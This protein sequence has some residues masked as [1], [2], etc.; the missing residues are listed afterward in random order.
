MFSAS[1]L[2]MT[3]M[4]QRSRFFAHCIMRL[5][6]I[7]MPFWAF[8]T[9]AA[10]STAGN[11]PIARPMKS[12]KPGVS[13]RCTRVSRCWRCTTA[14]LS[15]CWYCFSS[16]SKSQTVVP[17]STLPAL[18]MAPALSRSDSESVVLPEPP[19][20]TRAI[21]RMASGENFGMELLL[22]L[23]GVRPV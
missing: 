5:V 9:M 17:F 13:I 1:I 8:T 2:L 14:A 12:G 11:A 20:P 21:V 22:F 18:A 19:W 6:I 3:I 10:V 23:L 4:R 15:E 7:S 16:G